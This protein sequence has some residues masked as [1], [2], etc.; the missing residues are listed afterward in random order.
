MPRLVQ[1]IDGAGQ[2]VHVAQQL[3]A[4]HA[5]T[6]LL[7]A[8]L[9]QVHQALVAERHPDHQAI[10]DPGGELD[11][12][13]VAW[14]IL[15][16][17]SSAPLLHAPLAG[18][19]R[20]NF[21][22]TSKIAGHCLNIAEPA[23]A[24]QTH[25]RVAG[26]RL[27]AGLQDETQS[28]APRRKQ[29]SLGVASRLL[30]LLAGALA[31]CPECGEECAESSTAVPCMAKLPSQLLERLLLVLGDWCRDRGTLACRYGWFGRIFDLTCMLV[32]GSQGLG[33]PLLGPRNRRTMFV[34][35]VGRLPLKVRLRGFACC[36]QGLLGGGL[37]PGCFD[38]LAQG[39]QSR[40]KLVTAPGRGGGLL[41]GLGKRGGQSIAATSPMFAL[42]VRR[43]ARSACCVCR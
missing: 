13:Q 36:H 3:V 35:C 15:R 23:P 21:M 18:V 1:V 39:S 10:G 31:L 22:A 20:R 27:E 33:F 2:L 34:G 9:E 40:V 25:Q 4:R 14:R 19:G 8:G 28:R 5:R 37:G 42:G 12:E 11:I 38:L 16:I 41:F 43:V 6:P 26:D 32:A 29:V 30:R 17:T 7:Q 24:E